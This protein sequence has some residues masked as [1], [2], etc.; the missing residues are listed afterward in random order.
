MAARR[1][2]VGGG[3][4]FKRW[5]VHT[6]I[7]KLQHAEG[8]ESRTGDKRWETRHLSP[9]LKRFSCPVSSSSLSSHLDRVQS[10]WL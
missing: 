4:A 5:S 9:A 8:R 3:C 6:A 2:I 7:R 1:S 10:F